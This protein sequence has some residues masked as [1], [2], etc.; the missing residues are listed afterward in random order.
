MSMTT[1]VGNIR[2]F[3]VHC[4]CIV[5]AERLFSQAMPKECKR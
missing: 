3:V 4:D 5:K 2:M 1:V